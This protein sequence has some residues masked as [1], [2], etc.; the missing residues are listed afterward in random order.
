MWHYSR[1][2]RKEGDRLSSVGTICRRA[3][4]M[5]EV[6]FMVV[7]KNQGRGVGAALMKHL[8]AIPRSEGIQEL[9]A[10]VLPENGPMLKVFKKCGFVVETNAEPDVVHVIVR[11]S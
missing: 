6:A 3:A 7:D 9:I 8:A 5:A 2:L 11:S 10:E 4:G 1:W